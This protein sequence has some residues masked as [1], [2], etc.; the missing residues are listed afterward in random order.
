MHTSQ[1]P[2]VLAVAALLVT[3]T[4]CSE[5]PESQVLLSPSPNE[6]SLSR[7]NAGNG[8]LVAP[9]DGGQEVPVVVSNA[10]GNAVFKIARDGQ[11]VDYRLIVAGA[12]D[13]LQGHVHLAPAGSNG[14]V[15]AFLFNF[16]PIALNQP[17]VTR[18]GVIAT[19]TISA[20]DLIARNAVGFNGSMEQFIARLR[21]GGAYVNVHTGSNPGGEVRGQVK[22]GHGGH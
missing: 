13:L 1:Y 12:K 9:L 16:A 6:A 14:P 17:G 4:G 21:S 19:G 8:A 7:S 18:S 5:Q 2:L 22:G 10:S 3:T 15:V 11:S 20:A